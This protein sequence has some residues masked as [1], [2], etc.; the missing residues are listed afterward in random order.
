VVYSAAEIE[1]RILE[2]GQEISR[3]YAGTNPLL[4]GVLKGV[5]IFMADLYRAITIPA[6]VDFIAIANYSLQAREQG[7]VRLE[8][9]LELSMTGRHV[10]FVEDM[11]DTGLTLN[12]LLRTLRA[13]E[14]AS[15]E[16]CTLFDKA[17]RRLIPVPIKYKGFD[18]PDRFVVGYGLDHRE[19]YRNLPCVGLLKPEVLHKSEA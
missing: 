19:R 6:E 3:D 17:K 1:Q 18:L 14:P 4:I 11:V 16:V 8:K 10:L 15:L 12:Y 5:F 9:D 2:L 7:M 13:R